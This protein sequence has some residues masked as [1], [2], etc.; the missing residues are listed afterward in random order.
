MAT[1]LSLVNPLHS[2]LDVFGLKKSFLSASSSLAPTP[3]PKVSEPSSLFSPK[4]HPHVEEVTTEV[5]GYFIQ[6]W[7]FETQE[8]RKKFVGAGFSTVT[9]YYFPTAKDDRIH[10]ACRLL[11]LLFLIDGIVSS[12][13]PTA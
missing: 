12:F 4:C 13:L 11:T 1:F 2:L 6:H 9:C 7:P 8:A 3:L 5:N 10:F